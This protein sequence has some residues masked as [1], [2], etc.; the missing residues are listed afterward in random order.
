MNLSPAVVEEGHFE[1]GGNRE[2]LVSGSRCCEV[3]GPTPEYW[4]LIN[5]EL[6]NAVSDPSASLG[7]TI[8]ALRINI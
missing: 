2:H 6:P 4:L 5:A 7:M 1:R 8:L 3:R